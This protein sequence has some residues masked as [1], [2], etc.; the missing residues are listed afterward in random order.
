MDTRIRQVRLQSAN[1]LNVRRRSEPSSRSHQPPQYA[2]ATSI[3]EDLYELGAADRR[4][5]PVVKVSPAFSNS[6]IRSL[7]HGVEWRADRAPRLPCTLRHIHALQIE[8]FS[9]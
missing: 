3:H 7:R 8:L 2:N 4:I 5:N 6:M 9:A 1:E